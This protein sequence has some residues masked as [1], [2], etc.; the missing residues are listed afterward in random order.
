MGDDWRELAPEGFALPARDCRARA[1]AVA[2]HSGCAAGRRRGRSSSDASD[3]TRC[4]TCEQV[5]PVDAIVVGDDGP[6]FDHDACI[7][8][9][10]CQELCPP[11][12]IG[13]KVPPLARCS[14][15]AST[16][17]SD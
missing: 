12:A 2:R 9:Y 15:R 14:Q 8:C 17:P 7:R 11:Q 1:A 13:L 16:A 3:C 5:C 4:R 6:V 10:C